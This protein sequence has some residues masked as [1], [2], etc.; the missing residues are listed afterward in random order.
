MIGYFV[1]LGRG[2][3]LDGFDIIPLPMASG[4]NAFA[5]RTPASMRIPARISCRRVTN[6]PTRNSVSAGLILF[7]CHS[8]LNEAYN[9]LKSYKAFSACM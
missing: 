7:Q 2:K 8:N 3:T 6:L 1:A 4:G 5:P 9:Q